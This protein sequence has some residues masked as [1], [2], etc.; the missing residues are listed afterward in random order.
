M[1]ANLRIEDGTERLY[2]AVEVPFHQVRAPDVQFVVAAVLEPVDAR[3]LEEA[4]DDRTYFDAIADVRNSRTKAADAAHD[5][6]EIHAGLRR[7]VEHA[8]HLIVGERVDLD[9]HAGGAAFAR[10]LR[11]AHDQLAQP[12]AQ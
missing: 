1:L 9:N 2:T 6:V 5:E 7:A 8:D 4:A 11:L 10:V 12:R 3:V